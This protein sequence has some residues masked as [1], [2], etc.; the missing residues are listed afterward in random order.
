M[1]QWLRHSNLSD[2]LLLHLGQDL[3][4]LSSLKHLASVQRQQHQGSKSILPPS[5]AV[6]VPLLCLDKTVAGFNWNKN[7]LMT[8]ATHAALAIVIIIKSL[9]HYDNPHRLQLHSSLTYKN[10]LT[11]FSQLY[12]IWLNRNHC[13]QKILFILSRSKAQLS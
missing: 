8:V 13:D 2:Q 12:W 7:S 10:T 4:L 11:L 3:T 9:S 6:Y 1:R 5:T